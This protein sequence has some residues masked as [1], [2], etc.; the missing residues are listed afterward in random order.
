[1]GDRAMG[2]LKKVFAVISDMKKAADQHGLCDAGLIGLTDEKWP[3]TPEERRELLKAYVGLSDLHAHLG[4][5]LAQ[6]RY[7]MGSPPSIA[8]RKVE[9]GLF[10]ARMDGSQ[11]WEYAK[12]RTTEEAIGNLVL[13]LAK[14]EW[15][16]VSTEHKGRGG[17][18]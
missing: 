6:V 12:G 1:M 16:R 4:I 3:V 13:L 9:D 2:M 17:D 8:V 7:K 15:M 18:K 14:D 10:E 11:Q 5:M